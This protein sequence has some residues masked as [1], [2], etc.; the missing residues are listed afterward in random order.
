MRN[1]QGSVD[2]VVTISGV[3]LEDGAVY[4]GTKVYRFEF[5]TEENAMAFLDTSDEPDGLIDSN[6][7]AAMDPE[8][9][10]QTFGQ[11]QNV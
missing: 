1:F 3:V 6:M 11:G 9:Y 4:A 2:M 5:E 8:D 10:A 7:L